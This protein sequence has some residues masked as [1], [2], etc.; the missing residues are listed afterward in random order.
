MVDIL[1]KVVD[2]MKVNITWEK[3]KD[4]ENI[5]LMMEKYMKDFGK[6]GNNM[7]KVK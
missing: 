3:N 5:S 6:M 1:G 7:E 4:L 2:I